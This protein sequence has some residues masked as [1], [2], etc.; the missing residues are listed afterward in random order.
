VES[1]IIEK[2]LLL[3]KTGEDAALVT[4]TRTSGSTPRS[5][6]AKMLVFKDGRVYGTIGGGCG[7]AEVVRE[8]L[9]VLDT[10][11]PKKYYLDMTNDVAAD[12]GMVCGGNMEVFIDFFD[13]SD[14][15]SRQVL[16]AYLDSL[17]KKENPL[18]VTIAG[19]EDKKKFLLGRKMVFF[20]SGSESGD[21]GC[22]EITRHARALAG[23]FRAARK[24]G[25]VALT[26]QNEIQHLELLFEPG[27]LT[28][29]IIIL[30]GGH[31]A[32]PL[33]KMASIL[34]YSTVVVDDRP[35]FA[36]V[37]RFPEA[38]QVICSDFGSFLKGLEAGA[39][40]FIVIV[41]RGHRHDLECL[42]ETINQPAAYI[43]M[44]GSLRK[45]KGVV[46]QLE[47]EGVPGERLREVYSP[48]GLD[49]GAETPEEIAV[50]IM[51]EIVNVWRG[52]KIPKKY[53]I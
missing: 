49:I 24:P 41:T 1:A 28:P 7:E 33:V 25:L 23:Q 36:S 2:L 46:K 32:I 50:S 15:E 42:R 51:A 6:G 11:V 52:G 19:V 12:E 16:A 44:I 10:K 3:G 20:Q 31:I 34:G 47:L 43:G 45:V 48:I 40:T 27:V 29:Q 8:A 17:Q 14:N 5:P 53:N 21:L 26:G 18:L 39:Q 30:G 22:A 13:C 37:A 38:D 9:G 35:S 4:V